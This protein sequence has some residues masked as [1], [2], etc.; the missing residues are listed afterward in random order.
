MSSRSEVEAARILDPAA[1][2]EVKLAHARP[3]AWA[4][5]NKP[6]RAAWSAASPSA[7]GIADAETSAR[8]RSSYYCRCFASL[9]PAIAS[10]FCLAMSRPRRRAGAGVVSRLPI[11][12]S[13]SVSCRSRGSSAPIT[14]P[15]AIP[16][17][18]RTGA[19][20]SS[21]L[22]CVGPQVRAASAVVVARAVEGVFRLSHCDS[23]A[24]LSWGRPLCQRAVG[25]DGPRL[26]LPLDLPASP[27]RFACKEQR[28]RRQRSR[29]AA[30]PL[31]DRVDGFLGQIDALVLGAL[32]GVATRAF[33]ARAVTWSSSTVSI[34]RAARIDFDAG[35]GDADV[36]RAVIWAALQ[37]LRSPLNKPSAPRP[38]AA[39]RQITSDQPGR[40]GRSSARQARQRSRRSATSKPLREQDASGP[41]TIGTLRAST[42][43]PPMRLEKVELGLA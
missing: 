12:P 29:R 22:D 31:L 7:G 24:R 26:G 33:G 35:P 27:Q 25:F 37:A 36:S 32:H 13:N 5:Q 30:G 39:T 3:L 15:A 14:A 42:L 8:R 6:F 43:A 21:W 28:S 23:P 16:P 19:H 34:S 1:E 4:R 17:P 9:I 41:S 38:P 20:S 40:A 11:G 18:A 10:S 2:H